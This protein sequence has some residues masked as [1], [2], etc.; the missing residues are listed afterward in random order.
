M[1][2]AVVILAAGAGS[3][4]GGVAKALLKTRRGLPFLDQIVHTARAAGISRAIVVVGPP[5][6]AEVAAHAGTLGV[7][8]VENPL[9]DRGM[10]SS[11]ALG[12]GAL[13]ELE[14]DDGWLW[15]VDHPDV[16]VETLEAVRAAIGVHLAAR[17]TCD[18][19]GGHPP[20]IR[21]ALFADLW[22]CELEPE[23][24]RSVLARADMIDVPVH[25]RGTIRDIDTL[26]D[27]EIP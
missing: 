14:V 27:L 4:L 17:P 16:Q 24:A 1:S 11:I 13:L 2:S 22:R 12:F 20:L 6:G 25:D 15:P 18:G 3:R 19:K 23:G 21:R 7:A 26:D 5:F 10:A 9:P 8:V